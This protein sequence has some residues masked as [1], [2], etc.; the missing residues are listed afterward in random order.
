MLLGGELSF[1]REPPKAWQPLFPAT[2]RPVAEEL[3]YS[4]NRAL[5]HPC[6]TKNLLEVWQNLAIF[7]GRPI[8]G[9]I[10][11]LAIG[12]AIYSQQ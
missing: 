2:D 7:Y 4:R 3:K 11:T 1:W 9:A 6:A 12:V 8:G 5:R 10:E